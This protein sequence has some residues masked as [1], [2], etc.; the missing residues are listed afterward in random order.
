MSY[1]Y[2]LPFGAN[3]PYLRFPDWRRYVIDGWSI[4]GA[5]TVASGD[6]IYLTP[7]FNNTGGVV[8]ALQV[9]V[10]PGVDQHVSNQ[11]PAL[12]YNPAAFVQPPDFTIGNVSRTLSNLLNPGWQNFDMSLNKR[13]ALAA[14]RTLEFNATAFDFMNHANWNDPDNVIGSVATP[15]LDAGK[16]IGSRGGRVIQLGLRLSF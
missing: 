2:E 5:G 11:G 10:V 16:I 7:L 13:F 3:K 6:P 12:W 15:N 8:Q 4:S 9:D 14:E 1:T